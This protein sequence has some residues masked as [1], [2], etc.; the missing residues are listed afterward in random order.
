[1]NGNERTTKPMTNGDRLRAMS[2][3]ELAESMVHLWFNEHRFLW[4][5]VIKNGDFESFS[6]KQDAIKSTLDWLNSPAESA[7]L[8]DCE[9]AKSQDREES[10]ANAAL[11]AAA[12][13]MYEFIE[14][15]RSVEG[16]CAILKAKRYLPQ[17]LDK[18][19]EILKK[20]RGEK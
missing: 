10:D 17:I 5:G 12:P 1:M 18:L 16:Q 13:L 20:A 11:I 6:K 19:D 2:N 9:I 15:L 14:W 3:E 8:R 7:R 4:L